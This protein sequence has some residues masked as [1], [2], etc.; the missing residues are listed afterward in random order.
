MYNQTPLCDVPRHFA[1]LSHAPF[2]MQYLATVLRHCPSGGRT[3][4][5]GIG[6]GYGAIWL[7]LRGIAAEGID[8]A[9]GIVE[10]ARQINNILSGRAR[11][12]TGDLFSLYAPAFDAPRA[13]YNVIH[14]QGVLEHFTVPQIRA[15]L[16]QQVASADW[17]VFSVPSVYYPF[18]P[19]FG[20]ERLLPLEEWVDILQPFQVSELK[21][22]GDSRLGEQEHL[23][24]VLRGQEV[25]DK[26]RSLMAVPSEPYAQGISAIV[27][28]RDEER[29]IEACLQTLQGWTDEIIVCDMESRDNTVEIARRYTDKII[30]HPHIANFDRARNV[31]AMR[32]QYQWVFYLDA[33]ERV[34]EA[35]GSALRH[36]TETKG[37]EFEGLLLPF[38]HHFAGRWMHSLYPGYTAPRLLKNCKFIF[39]ARLHGG[40]QVNGR[41]LQFPADNPELALVH[42]S[43]DSLAHYLD[44]LNRYTDGE[45]ANMQRDGKAFHWQAAIRHF[46]QDLRSYYDNAAA[47]AKDGVHGF[48]Y[49]FLSAFYRFEQ[50]AKLYERRCHGGQLQEWETTVPQSAEQVLEYALE[51]LREK[52]LPQVPALRV[53]EADN[54]FTQYSEGGKQTLDIAPEDAQNAAQCSAQSAAQVV[55][56]GPLRDPSGYGEECR[57]FLF[58]LQDA[59]VPVAA[60]TLPWSHDEVQL[61]AA[62]SRRLSHAEQQEVQPGFIQIVQNFPPAFTRHPQADVVIGRTM[63]ET[64]RLPPEWVKGC[65]GMDFIWVP[66]E[67][68]RQ[69]FA[70]AGVDANKLIVVP[71]CFDPQPFLNLAP[72]LALADEIKQRNR[73]TFLSVFDWTLHK[74]WDVLLRAF[75]QAFDGRD[76]VALVLKVWSS[77]GYEPEQIVKQAAEL[78]RNEL[79]HDL[80]TDNRIRFVT[81]SLSREELPALYQAADAFVLPS[82]GEGW[83]R[84]YMEAMACGLPVIGTNWSGNTAFMTAETSY[85][86]DYEVQ[87]VP[88]A[89]WREIPTYRGH[90]W[91]EPNSDHLQELMRHVFHN[92]EQAALIGQ[93]ARHEV[94]TRFSRQAVGKIMRR[95]LDCVRDQLRPPQR[96][97]ITLTKTKQAPSQKDEADNAHPCSEVI[98]K[99]RSPIAVRWEGAQFSWHSLGHVNRELCRGLLEND[100]SP[101]NKN[102]TNR[103]FTNEPVI[104]LS[105]VSTEPNAFL[106]ADEPRFKALAQHCFAPLS[107]AAHVH[108]RHFF[109]PRFEIPEEG[110]LVLMQPWEYGYLPA[111]WIDPILKNVAEVWCN[112]TY[113]RDVYEKSGVPKKMLHLIPLGVDT[114]IFHPAAPPYVFTTEA[115]AS[116]LNEDKQKPFTFLF[117]GG[118]LH[119]KGIDILLA[120]YQRAFSAQDNVCLVIKDTG[121]QTVYRG[122]NEQEQIL[123]LTQDASCAPLVY[124][125]NDLS[126]HQLAGVYTAADCLVQP[127]RGEG[128][129]L[130]VLEAMA[131]GVPVVVPEGGPTDD[132]VD[133]TVGWR[134]AA[135]RQ[136]FGITASGHGHIGNYDCT[137][138]TWMFEVDVDDLAQLLRQVYEERDEAARRGA[139]ATQR[140]QESWTWQDSAAVVLQRLHALAEKPRPIV[141]EK[142]RTQSSI[143]METGDVTPQAVQNDEESVQTVPLSA[144]PVSAMPLSEVPLS[145]KAVLAEPVSSAPVSE[146]HLTDVLPADRYLTPGQE[147]STRHKPTISLCMIVKNEERV[148]GDCLQSAKPYVDEIIIVDTGSTDRT[149]EIAQAH[150]ARVFHF[151]WCDSFSAARNESLQH[152]TGDWIFWMDADDTLPAQCG[153]KLHDLVALA[154]A[155]TTGFLMQVHIPPAPGESGF[156]VVDHVKLFRNRPELR[157][158]GRIH[159]QILESIYRAGGSVERSDLYVVHSGYDYS[160]QGQDHKRERDLLLLAKDLEERPNHPF[161]LFNIGMTAYHLKDYA[162]AIP[163]LER[164]LSLCKPR[165][166]IVRKVYA[167]LAGCYLS[168]GDVDQAKAFVQQ[169]LD[170]FPHDPELLFRAGIV[171]RELGELQS[172]EQSYLKLLTAREVGHIDSLDVSITGFKAHHNL[173]LIYRDMNQWQQ[174]EAQWLAA[175]RDNPDFVLS[176]LGLG[177]LYLQTGRFVEARRVVTQLRTIA[178]EEAQRLQQHI[179]SN[180]SNSQ[181]EAI[182]TA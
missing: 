99:E 177:E 149:V 33:D 160:P 7:S 158:E 137:G 120:A 17:V 181:L 24:C 97:S 152:A 146:V 1:S 128:F 118:T 131:C 111:A 86:L 34:P 76:D 87:P 22:Y 57:N 64:D 70:D 134:I 166:S 30:V 12:E 36:L 21:Y 164:C 20:D 4:E 141:E 115:G 91:A 16:A 83:G 81:K 13:R 2:L 169:G 175:V 173:A 56:S 19:E 108:V 80:L 150:N 125:D 143:N 102:C 85:L 67:F 163:A 117:I 42:Y 144:V 65:N 114:Q 167:M 133:E 74:G 63:F 119:R 95:E 51:V 179:P 136:P 59:G 11:F 84:P 135:K 31:S 168:C 35:L 38:R 112:S 172:A 142:E 32:A 62:E 103:N 10:R 162:Q 6:S 182:A 58:A 165:E 75:V 148:L 15:A 109:P 14:H 96:E 155:R 47:G 147:A 156:T 8:Y 159:E 171:Y 29:H 40:A 28:T 98:E 9:P 122:Q 45:A 23:L 132:F 49:S 66:S 106:P 90:Q 101:E 138:P 161:V 139:N 41:I 176:W 26:L 48:L 46:A 27:H 140:V 92:R 78:L 44:K 52:P 71:G 61:D 93:R 37:D 110:H 129:C 154:E 69:T 151:P 126:A 178:P 180:T 123:Q 39:N 55:W 50:H 5:T 157:F 116:R 94:T 88:Q 104:E 153:E 113:V 3:L 89:G 100:S 60:Q 124:L 130:P 79:G 82:R 77:M 105:L 174:A 72:P 170:L 107:Q 68:N 73:F 53:A 25:D 18:E 145:A 127:Y 121:T 43:Y 54:T